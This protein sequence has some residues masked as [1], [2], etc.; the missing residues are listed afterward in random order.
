MLTNSVGTTAKFTAGQGVHSRFTGIFE[1][2]GNFLASGESSAFALPNGELRLGASAIANF[3]TLSTLCRFGALTGTGFFG[4]WG[5]HSRMPF[6]IGDDRS[7]T[8][9][10]AGMLKAYNTDT[11]GNNTPV[12]GCRFIKT[13]TS[14][15]RISGTTND[16]R[17]AFT[18][19]K[20]M[21]VTGADSTG[22]NLGALGRGPVYLGDDGTLAN[23]SLGLMTD[24]PYIVGNKI[25]IKATAS[26]VTITLG[27]NQ[28]IGA[29]SF[30]NELNLTRDV[31]L[32][33]ANTDSPNG[34]TFSGAITG[35]GG[36][37]KTGVGT[38]YLTGAVDYAGPTAV[39]AG[40][41][42]V[43]DG[44]TLTNTLTVTALA[45]G[46]G[47]LVVDGNLTLGEGAT[48][49]VSTS[50]SLVRG[51]T[52]TLLT[53][54]GSRTGSFASVTGLPDD[55]HVSFLSNSLILYYAPPGTLIQVH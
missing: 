46:S 41:L 54:T 17:Q 53:W 34:V 6:Y 39:Q 4:G 18:V 33:A 11:G 27:G 23:E 45:G 5:D 29:S 24:G 12:T 14:T 16:I 40:Q 52:Y 48:L 21:V 49:A 30:T 37:T 31:V 9:E 2:P 35:P 20:G 13:G 51:E 7:E 15:W 19:R 3:G 1:V 55:W 38:V 26:D 50:G 8:F 36:I 47:T 42:F 10:F 43:P 32:T 44:T 25:E 28:T 22:V